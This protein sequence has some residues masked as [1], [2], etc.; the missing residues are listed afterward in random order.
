MI[1]TPIPAE[2]FDPFFSQIGDGEWNACIGRQ[3]DEQNYVD[4]YMEAALEL[5]T[6]VIDKEQYGKRDTLAMPILFNARHAVELSLKFVIKRLNEIGILAVQLPMDHDIKA[7]WDH[8]NTATLGDSLLRNQMVCLR[9]FVISLHKVDPDGQQL[10][11]SETTDGRQS[12]SDK[13]VCDLALI[14]NSL[15]QMRIL[16]SGITQRAIQLV[17]ERAT[18]TFTSECS[19]SDLLLIARA[20]PPR[21]RWSEPAFATVKQDLMRRFGL[22]GRKLSEAVRSI[23]RHRE[24]GGL[25]GLE[26]PFAYMTDEHALFVAQEWSKLHPPR[27]ESEDL[28]VDYFDTARLRSMNERGKVRTAVF[29]A[30]IATLSLEETADLETIF[31]VGR[32]AFPCEFYEKRLTVALR[33]QA[34]AGELAA[35]VNHLLSKTNLLEAL[36]RGSDILGRRNLAASLRALRPD[37]SR[38]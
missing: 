2:T 14:R 18:G 4:G 29:E 3:G 26:F 13:F 35:S 8:I 5:V 9:S 17:E 16:L 24:M 19:R 33:R 7:H 34:V 11:Y 21:I 27:A 15:S 38:R 30:V 31:Y 23:E 10:R 25:I 20:L 22:S 12:L 32:D 6:A 37:L 28:S 1:S 36:A